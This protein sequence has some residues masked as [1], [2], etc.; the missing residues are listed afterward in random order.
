MN[1]IE[2]KIIQK[3]FHKLMCNRVL[4]L[5]KVI[6]KMFHKLMCNRVLILHKIIWKMFH[7]FLCVTQKFCVP[8]NLIRQCIVPISQLKLVVPIHY[9]R[10]QFPWY[11]W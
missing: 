2:H 9:I 7:K 5:H 11:P 3:M 10:V 4:I 1:K 8:C 6:R